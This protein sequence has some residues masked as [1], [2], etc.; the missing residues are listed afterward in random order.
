MKII[1][2]FYSGLGG[3]SSVAF[4]LIEADKDKAFDNFIIFYGIEEVPQAYINKCEELGVA[5]FCVKKNKGLDTSSQK[6]VIAILKSVQPAVILLHSI[7]LIVPVYYYSL[8]KRTKIISVEHQANHLKTKTEWIW[9][10][11]LMRL[12]ANVVFLTELYRSQVEKKLGFFYIPAKARVINNGINTDFFK[13]ADGER[14]G[15]TGTLRIGMLSRLT[16][17]KDH[18]TLIRSFKALLQNKSG[19]YRIELH[20]AG[21]GEMKPV[22]QELVRELDLA[23]NIHFP[24]MI[25]ESG[26]ADFLNDM[27]IYVHASL[28]ETMSTAI[29]QAMACGKPIVASDVDGI[30]NMIVAG[31]TG[32]LVPV[33]NV[34]A[35]TEQI[36]KLLSGSHLRETLGKNALEYAREN[37]TNQVMF[38]KYA[39][40]FA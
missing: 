27:H 28:G 38:K 29:M 37:F 8:R 25:P 31:K 33:K 34:N 32:L 13:P 15:L 23:G 24:G 6:Q 20:I 26:I 1:Q 10:R 17:I 11:L 40:L 16:A 21:E 18:I 12:S 3:H 19:E 39:A 22:L 35:L 9:S 36:G 2:I 4:S 5:Y 30:N 7:T 14:Q